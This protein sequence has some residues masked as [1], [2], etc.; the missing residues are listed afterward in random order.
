MAD[1]FEEI[2]KIK[3]IAGSEVKA[4]MEGMIAEIDLV[5]Q[6]LGSAETLLIMLVKMFYTITIHMSLH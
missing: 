1:F 2:M 6:N 5:K 4:D 3:A